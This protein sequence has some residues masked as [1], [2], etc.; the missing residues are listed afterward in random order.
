ME[1]SALFEIPRKPLEG[2]PCNG[3]GLCCAT[4]LCALALELLEA[5]EAPCPA[6]EFANGRFWCGLVRKPSRYCGTP[7]LSDRLIRSF[8]ERALAIGEGCDAEE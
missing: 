3:C 2:A 8:I 6:M 5:R 7:P 4:A 1:D